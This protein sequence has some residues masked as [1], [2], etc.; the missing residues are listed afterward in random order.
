MLR[1][2]W[3]EFDNNIKISCINLLNKAFEHNLKYIIEDDME[4]IPDSIKITLEKKLERSFD[5]LSLELNLWK[6][7]RRDCNLPMPT[8]RYLKPHIISKWNLM[9]PPSDTM[10]KIID[11][12]CTALPVNGSQAPAISRLLK[13]CAY[14]SMKM[15]QACTSKKI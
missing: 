7:T 14:D 13:Y 5:E 3:V 15:C 12:I 2:T 9:K 8:C 4:F 1:G 11:S 6:A 10:T